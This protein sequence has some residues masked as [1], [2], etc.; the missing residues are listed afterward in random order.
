MPR[1]T[2]DVIDQAIRENRHWEILVSTFT[3]VFISVGVAIILWSM[4]HNQPIATLAGVIES[5]LFWPAMSVAMRT[6]R[7]NI[8][9]RL[10]EVPLEKSQTGAEAAEMLQRVF[11]SHFRDDAGAKKRQI[12]VKHDRPSANI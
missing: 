3:A 7:A 9:L 8:M 11:E 2:S 12:K 6:R 10:L 1:S 4:I 5:A